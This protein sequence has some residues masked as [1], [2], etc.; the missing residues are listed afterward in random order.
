MISLLAFGLAFSKD[1]CERKA[2]ETPPVHGK[3]KD[4]EE[5]AVET[6][7]LWLKLGGRCV[8]YLEDIDK[9]VDYLGVQSTRI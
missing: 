6:T 3:D 9:L 7:W 1:V 5:P 8:V 2:V 4:D